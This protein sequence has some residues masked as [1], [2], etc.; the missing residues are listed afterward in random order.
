MEKPGTLPVILING[1]LSESVF[2]FVRIGETSSGNSA[3]VLQ[4]R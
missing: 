2:V 1:A 3:C 4:T